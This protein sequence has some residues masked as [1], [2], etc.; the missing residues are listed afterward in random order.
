VVVNYYIDGRPDKIR[1]VMEVGS[2]RGKAASEQQKEA[3][4]QQLRTY[5][6]MMGREGAWWERL[7]IGVALLGTEV[8]FSRPLQVENG[9][10]KWTNLTKWYSIYSQKFTDE[11][12]K[13]AK[14]I[15]EDV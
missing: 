12:N 3:I 14:V 5:M 10:T 6:V 4:I 8:A 9:E 1:L 15:E 13:I 11:M 2:L 7:V